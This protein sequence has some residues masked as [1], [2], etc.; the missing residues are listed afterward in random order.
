VAVVRLTGLPAEVGDLDAVIQD[1]HVVA[2][3]FAGGSV[4]PDGG[5][6]ALEAAPGEGAAGEGAIGDEELARLLAVQLSEW[7]AGRR[8]R[9]DVPV[10]PRVTSEFRRRVY[11][12]LERVPPG[13]VVT[14]GELAARVGAPGAARAVGT[15]MATN[16]LPFLVPCHRVVPA[17]G[18][19]GSYGGGTSV[20]AWLLGLEAGRC[21]PAGN[22]VP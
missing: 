14:Y 7:F 4:A 5:V 11:A 17:S 22:H 20:K 10:A 1:G 21:Q 16:P 15:A 8:R 2:L 9:V 18:G 13:E 12:E 6:S 19:T 3:R